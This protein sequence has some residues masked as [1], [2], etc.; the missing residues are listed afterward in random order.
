M[1]STFKA[2][3]LA[4]P[5]LSRSLCAATAV[6]LVLTILPFGINAETAPPFPVLLKEALSSAPQLAESRANIDAAKSQAQ[7]ATAWRNPSVGVE[8]ENFNADRGSNAYSGR[9]TTYNVTQPFEIGGKREARKSAAS[10]SVT[11]AE[12]SD[13]Q[14]HVD[15]AAEFATAYAEAE[16]ARARMTISANDVKRA[17]DD[18][19]VANAL[20]EAG[21]EAALRL[22]QS[23]AAL[24]SANARFEAGRADYL[25]ALARLSSMVGASEPYTDVTPFLLTRAQ[26]LP[27]IQMTDPGNAPVVASARAER[28]ASAAR[29]RVEQTR[30]TPDLDF[31]LG[32]RQ[33]P[34]QGSDNALVAGFSMSIPLW[35]RN[36]GGV[37]AAEAQRRAAEARLMS[38]QAVASADQRSAMAQST[39][40]DARLKAA[41]DAQSFAAEAYRLARI[42]Y[43]AG[44]TSLIELL[45][46]RRAL[47][48]AELAL[49]DTRLDRVRA[50]VALARINGQCPFGE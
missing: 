19:K 37:G 1:T 22:S 24:S 9:Q 6:A 15:F 42:G 43:D 23:Q 49:V 21:K 2:L 46:T 33:F 45:Q 35:D 48:D 47:A 18:L 30:S 12:A 16:A 7:Q 14:V 39:A 4:R 32:L 8:V 20:V 26:S 38:A 34:G 40:S 13:R 28:D 27:A 31:S 11:A 50:V 5:R 25:S 3:A 41:A 36:R 17:E 10:A 29:V 44:R